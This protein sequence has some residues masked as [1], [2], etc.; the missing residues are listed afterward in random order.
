MAAFTD[1]VELRLKIKDPLGVIA[2]LSVADETAR[3]AITSPGRQTAYKQLDTGTYYIYDTDLAS[4]EALD[5]LISDARIETL[6]DLYGIAKSCAR[7]VKDIMAELGQKL[8]ISRT[9]DGAG[10]TQYQSL[11]DLYEFYKALSGTFEEEASEDAGTSTGRYLRMRKPC[12]GG[13][14]LT[15]SS[16]SCL[17]LRA[18]Q[19]LAQI[20]GK[21]SLQQLILIFLRHVSIASTLM[22]RITEHMS[23]KSTGLMYISQS[24]I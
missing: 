12:I 1:I 19:S 20:I 6:I 16:S 18:L 7:V 21:P 24:V 4:W 9:Q 10:S 17:I 13:G 23:K 2:I 5:L 8:Y 15:S 14:M 3:L 22:T 11:H